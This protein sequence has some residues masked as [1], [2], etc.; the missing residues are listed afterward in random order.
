MSSSSSTSSS[1]LFTQRLN[2]S[3]E[4]KKLA[5]VQ[6]LLEKAQSV[7]E[8]QIP[9]V[10]HF[11][12]NG[13]VRLLVTDRSFLPAA[14]KSFVV[15]SKAMALACDAWGR[16]FNGNFKEAQPVDVREVPLPDDDAASLLILLNIVH[17]RF[18][19]VPPH[20][21]FHT[22][23]AV[24]V[25]TDKYGATSLVRPWYRSWTA[26]LQ[27]Q[28]LIPWF[29]DWLW[30]SW[31]LGQHESFERLAAHLV[32]TIRVDNTGK[33]ITDKGRVLNPLDSSQHLPPDI[34]GE[35]HL[36][37][38]YCC[39]LTKYGLENIIAIRQKAI[40]D[41][42]QAY[43]EL[44]DKFTIAF[45][46]GRTICQGRDSKSECDAMAFGSLTLPLRSTGLSLEKAKAADLNWS[47]NEFSAKLQG[48]KVFCYHS[49]AGSF[50][51]CSNSSLGVTL[52]QSVQQVLQ[53]L[54]SP[55]L[56]SHRRHL[57]RQWQILN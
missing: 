46:S 5:K 27:D 37:P 13:D 18:K 11:D 39:R 47:L 34:I 25:L 30:I 50:S 16:M 8:S 14:K 32:K 9:D 1:E 12:P 28:L 19:D 29:E 23:V 43:Y 53:S 21:S 52:Q 33:C 45:R 22:L 6:H 31:E 38:F 54:P 10:V 44:V 48:V 42:L 35:S 55:L 3:D 49:R 4:S 17:L 24:A 15:S 2:L 7:V 36:E 40:S 56:N 20:L 26:G 51:S 57:N 41:L